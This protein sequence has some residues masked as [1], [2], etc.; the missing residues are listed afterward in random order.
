MHHQFVNVIQPF[1]ADR[2][3]LVGPKSGVAALPITNPLQLGDT[4]T[5]QIASLVEEVVVLVLLLNKYSKPRGKG[6]QRV[7]APD[8]DQQLSGDQD[9]LTPFF[10]SDNLMPVWADQASHGPGD[11]AHSAQVMSPVEGRV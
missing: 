7:P 5:D 11:T 4:R 6:W 2:A 10:V 9:L 3:L 8:C 1:W